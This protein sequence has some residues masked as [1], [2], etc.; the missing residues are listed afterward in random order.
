[1][2]LCIR[3]WSSVVY[4]KIFTTDRH[5]CTQIKKFNVITSQHKLGSTYLLWTPAFAGECNFYK[6]LQYLWLKKLKF[7]FIHLHQAIF[8]RHHGFEV[9]IGFG[10]HAGEEETRGFNLT[11]VEFFITLA[12]F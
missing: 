10:E 1:M 9:P 3:L 11:F 7:C 12:C 4:Y 5:G 2:R 8:T 6:C